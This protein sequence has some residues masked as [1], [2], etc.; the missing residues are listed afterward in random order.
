MWVAGVSEGKGPGAEEVKGTTDGGL[1]LLLGKKKVRPWRDSAASWGICVTRMCLEVVFLN[2]QTCKQKYKTSKKGVCEACTPLQ[3]K[4]GET[5]DVEEPPEVI[6]DSN[7]EEWRCKQQRT[8][9]FYI[10]VQ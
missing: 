7:H 5:L 1:L 10:S 6:G 2:G 3:W 4:M 8:G 9:T